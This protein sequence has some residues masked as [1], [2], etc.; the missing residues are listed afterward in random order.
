MVSKRGY[1]WMKYHVDVLHNVIDQ[2]AAMQKAAPPG[3][4]VHYDFNADSSAIEVVDPESRPVLQFARD[5]DGL[6]GWIGTYQ[7]S[8]EVLVCGDPCA[9]VSEKEALPVLA[10]QRRIFL[11]PGYLHPGARER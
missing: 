5:E 7:K 1:H 8:G 11:Y 4:K 6:V 2:T 9:T 10:R 3:F